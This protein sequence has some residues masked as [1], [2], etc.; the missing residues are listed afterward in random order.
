MWNSRLQ[1]AGSTEQ[2][3]R[4]TLKKA[5][6]ELMLTVQ[7]LSALL[8][9]DFF[10]SSLPPKEEEVEFILSCPWR[11]RGTG[12]SGLSMG[13]R[14]ERQYSGESTFFACSYSGFDS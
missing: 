2:P 13:Q 1:T 11:K 7:H 10:S 8:Q 5:A 6:R 12:E 4:A 14:L 3:V 9:E